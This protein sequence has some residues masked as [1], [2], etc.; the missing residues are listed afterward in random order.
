MQDIL[1]RAKIHV[2]EVREETDRY[3]VT[4]ATLEELTAMNL[5][6]LIQATIQNSRN[7]QNPT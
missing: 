6:K 3:N 1:K 5:L 7:S 2:I 4:S